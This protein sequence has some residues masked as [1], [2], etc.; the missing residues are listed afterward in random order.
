MRIKKIIIL[1]SGVVGLISVFLPVVFHV[2]P[3]YLYQFWSWGYTLFFG[4]NSSEV[5]ASNNTELEFLIPALISMFLILASS[6][7]V[8]I[9]SIKGLRVDEINT[10][11]SL[12][13]G[14]MTV[15]TPLL[16]MISWHFI[17]TIGKGYPIFWGSYGT[18]NYYLPS[19]SFLLQFLAGGFTL[20]S[21]LMIMMKNKK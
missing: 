5:G 17:Y 4:L 14:I 7:M 15:A 8:L 12:V 16:L 21:S 13:G 19:F 9:S 2:S 3:N 6:S 1:L 11:I 20:L 18:E 10:K